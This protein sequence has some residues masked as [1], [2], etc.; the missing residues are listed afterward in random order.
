MLNSKTEAINLLAF[1]DRI[2]GEI[3]K[4]RDQGGWLHPEELVSFVEDY[5]A[6]YHPGTTI[7]SVP[8]KP[9]VFNKGKLQ[10]IPAT[11]GLLNKVNRELELKLRAIAQRRDISLDQVQLA[12]GVIFV[13]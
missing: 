2:L 8:N 1:S 10:M 7:E 4:S 13:E 9:H 3:T 5:F 6:R 12:A 11:E